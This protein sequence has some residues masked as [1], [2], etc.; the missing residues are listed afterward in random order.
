MA[1]SGASDGAGPSWSE[2]ID[3]A[4]LAPE[5]RVHRG[6]QTSDLIS[7]LP[8]FRVPSKGGEKKGKTGRVP[9]Q[10]ATWFHLANKAALNRSAEKGVNDR[11]QYVNKAAIL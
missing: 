5:E 9:G 4:E 1:K 7:T 11:R 3:L 10:T 8:L 6:V 2:P